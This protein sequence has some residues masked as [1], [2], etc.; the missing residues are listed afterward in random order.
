M[1][2]VRFQVPD[3]ISSRLDPE[4]A[5]FHLVS[6]TTPLNPR[7][8]GS[9]DPSCR[10]L[11]A[12]NAIIIKKTSRTTTKHAGPAIYARAAS[13]ALPSNKF[14]S[15]CWLDATRSGRLRWNNSLYARAPD[16]SFLG[17]RG[18][19][20]ETIFYQGYAWS[21]TW[22]TQF[23]ACGYVITRN[24]WTSGSRNQIFAVKGQHQ[25]LHDDMSTVVCLDMCV[26]CR[27][28]RLKLSI[29][30]CSRVDKSGSY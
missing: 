19:A 6:R 23:D 4:I 11:F 22:S 28:L 30:L 18:V 14:K 8:E 25:T 3:K 9:G 29:A 27:R 13:K 21:T 24:H 20:R 12:Q 26:L 5:V 10:E 1:T 17:L 7:K 16:P 2:G 15:R